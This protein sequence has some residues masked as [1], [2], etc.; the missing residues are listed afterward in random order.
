[1][2]EQTTWQLLLLAPSPGEQ[3]MWC[4]PGNGAQVGAQASFRLASAAT[5]AAT[6]TTKSAA[7][8]EQGFVD[9]SS[10]KA[11]PPNPSPLGRSQPSGMVFVEGFNKLCHSKI[12]LF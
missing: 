12:D 8:S 4:G 2:L 11:P 6:T 3:Q 1:M 5:K 10:Q 9:V 7:Q